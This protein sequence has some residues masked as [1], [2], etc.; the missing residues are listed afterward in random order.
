MYIANTA[1]DQQAMLQAIGVDTLDDLFLDVPADYRFP[2]LHLP[3]ALSELEAMAEMADLAGRNEETRGTPCFLGAGAYHHF[4]PSIVDFV[5]RKPEFFTAYTPYQPEISQGT[6]QAHFEYQS[7]LVQLTGMEVSN[8]SHYDG[9]TACAEAMIMALSVARGKRRQVIVSPTLHPQYRAVMRTYAQGVGESVLGDDRPHG[10]LDA[11]AELL[12]AETACLIV[13]NPDFLGRQY[14][15]SAMQRLADRVHAAGALFVVAV[16]PISLGLFDPP[17]AYGADIVVGEGQPLG[18][19]LN[20]GGPYLGFFTTKRQHVHKSAGRIVG[21]TVDADG[22]R[23]FVVTLS[24]REQHIRRE[25]ASSNICSNQALN[26]LAAA[27]YLAALGPQGL[28]EVAEL[29]YHKA[30]FAARLIDRLPGYAVLEQPFFHEFVVHTPRPPA[31]I[32]ARLLDDYGILGGYDLGQDYP[33]LAHHLLLCATEMN[34]REEI[35]ALVM[36]LG[37]MGE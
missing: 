17:G 6:L 16:N 25:R 27:V 32:N 14:P 15:P 22:Q 11:L 7:M 36:A 34:T 5:L 19:A 2:T 4:I 30:H 37:D 12:T 33:D 35:E 1:A 24:S 9:A 8:V 21:M 28:R 31:E 23:G 20:F 10:D 26:A 3:P 29:C 18:N 13:Q